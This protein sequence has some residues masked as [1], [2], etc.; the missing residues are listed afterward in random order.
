MRGGTHDDLCRSGWRARGDV[1]S[2]GG[3]PTTSLT[4]PA[5]AVAAPPRLVNRDYDRQIGGLGKALVARG[6]V[7]ERRGSE[8]LG[9]VV[10]RGVKTWLDRHWGGIRHVGLG[11]SIMGSFHHAIEAD[12]GFVKELACDLRAVALQE[13]E[14]D[15][16]RPHVAFVFTAT[17]RE[18]VLVGAGVEYLNGQIPHLGTEIL[19]L[20][21]EVLVSQVKAMDLESVLEMAQDVYW[22]GCEDEKEFVRDVLGEDE[23]YEGMT[24]AELDRRV[25]A[26]LLR[27][28]AKVGKAAMAKAA[29]HGE[30]VVRN[31]AALLTN[32][33]LVWKKGETPFKSNRELHDLMDWAVATPHVPTL[34]GW[35]DHEIAHQAGD[36]YFESAWNSG[37]YMPCP[38]VGMELIAL[39]DAD[40]L[41]RIEKRWPFHRGEM[42]SSS[43]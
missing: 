35:A 32:L 7:L 18:D 20:S 31:A 37:E 11:C 39:E 6:V 5:I 21:S 27:G 25:P 28:S 9:K 19:R 24:R 14:V 16:E 1:H 38:F 22:S 10:E 8:P 2:I 40:P 42:A 23:E 3:A 41:S 30:E 13:Y 36:A 29:A 34:I 17:G 26:V 33:R 4:L 12:P 43:A 15:I